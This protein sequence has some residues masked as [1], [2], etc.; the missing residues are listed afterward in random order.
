MCSELGQKDEHC[1]LSHVGS[2]KAKTLRSREGNGGCQHWREG[3][4]DRSK[5]KKV[6]EPFGP[7]VQSLC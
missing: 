7:R 2:K 4:Q 3:N 1:I 6:I 5:R